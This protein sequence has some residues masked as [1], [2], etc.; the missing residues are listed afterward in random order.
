MPDTD[1][2]IEELHKIRRKLYAKA[3]G[4]PAAYVRYLRQR[5]A[6]R[7][8]AKPPGDEPAKVVVKKTQKGNK[9]LSPA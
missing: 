2:P 9:S 8:Q 1:D 6:E 5:Q 3:G 7:Q 4:T